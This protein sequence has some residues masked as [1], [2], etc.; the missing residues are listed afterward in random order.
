[1]F[2]GFPS[3]GAEA[4]L[5]VRDGRAELVAA[6][7]PARNRYGVVRWHQEIAR[8]T[9]A[10]MLRGRLSFGDG[11][12]VPFPSAL[13]VWGA[14]PQQIA[15]L[16]AEFPYRLAYRGRKPLM[17]GSSGTVMIGHFW[18]AT[19]RYLFGCSRVQGQKQELIV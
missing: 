13:V 2:I 8:S 12:P 10:V 14:C 5:G 9:H 6:L 11:T 15:A 7:L 16:R 4:R 3:L 17:I 19:L 18:P 1:M